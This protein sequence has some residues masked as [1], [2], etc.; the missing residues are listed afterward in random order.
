MALWN[1][2]WISQLWRYFGVCSI[3]FC[4]NAEGMVSCFVFFVI[5][6]ELTLL[7]G[8]VWKGSYPV[9]VILQ[10]WKLPTATLLEL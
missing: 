9:A 4:S 7:G 3:L 6:A 8:N 1:L 10:T 5:L 2:L